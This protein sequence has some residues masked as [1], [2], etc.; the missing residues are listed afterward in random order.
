MVKVAVKVAGVVHSDERVVVVVVIIVV[1][2]VVV[3]VA[4]AT[5]AVAAAL[6]AS[7]RAARG[8]PAPL[9]LPL[10]PVRRRDGVHQFRLFSPRRLRGDELRDAL[11][12]AVAHRVQHVPLRP[13]VPLEEPLQR[14]LGAVPQQ[15]E[16]G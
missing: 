2:I 6:P 15:R 11:A 4:A 9:R 10:A 13:P 12:R 1:V 8:S 14:A 3:I 5:A 16:R 7:S